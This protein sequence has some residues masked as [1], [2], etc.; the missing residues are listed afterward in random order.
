MKRR[1]LIITP[2]GTN[3]FFDDLYDKN[4]HWKSN[5]EIQ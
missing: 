5:L 1:A 4:N 2:T 3:M